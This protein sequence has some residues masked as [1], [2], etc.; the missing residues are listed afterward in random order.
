MKYLIKIMGLCLVAVALSAV[1][2]ASASAAEP[3]LVKKGGGAIV[4]K[5]FTG[6]GLGTKFV[7]ETK[8]QG[9]ITCTALKA[10]G[11]VKSATESESTVLFTT[12]STASILKC[13]T[14]GAATGEI[15]TGISIRPRWSPGFIGSKVLLLVTILPG[16]RQI[17]INCGGTTQTL[18]VNGGFLVS[19]GNVNE[20]H[21]ILKL[22]AK[23]TGGVQEFTEFETEKKEKVKTILETEGEGLKKFGKTQSGEEAGEEATFEEEVEFI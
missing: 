21:K 13:S 17:I 1:V 5:K 7:L 22:E 20:P 9:T 3:E 16:T 12:C 14:G 19:A 11:E 4:K 2:V 18:K 6:K 23:Q 10:T 15:V 8:G